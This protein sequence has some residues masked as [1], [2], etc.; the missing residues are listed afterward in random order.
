MFIYTLK[1]GRLSILYP[2]LATSY[3]W[4]VLFSQIFLKE[5]FPAYKWVGIGLIIISVVIITR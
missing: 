1:Y 5:P 4:V 3:I 2:V